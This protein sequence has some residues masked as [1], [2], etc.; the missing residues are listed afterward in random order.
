VSA[1]ARSPSDAIA[2]TTVVAVDARTAFAVFT[3]DVDLWWRREP[4]FRARGDGVVRFDPGVGGRLIEEAA[5]GGDPIELARVTVWEPGARLVLA[6][7]GASRGAGAVTEV[8]VRFEPEPGPDHD[9]TRVTIEHR[10]W[11]AIPIDHPV[12]CGGLVGGAFTSVI[13]S[14]WGDLATAL[15]ARITSA[16]PRSAR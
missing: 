1:A 10:G 5:R 2:V 15:R 8:E 9:A 3:D 4:R 14:W 11:D 16:A 13:G 6:W 7:T 12:R